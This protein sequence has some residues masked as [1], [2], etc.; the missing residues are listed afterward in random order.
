MT[1]P[2]PTARTRPAR[3]DVAGTLTAGVVLSAAGLAALLLSA[4]PG[5]LTHAQGF[6]DGEGEG[7]LGA[8]KSYVRN[9]VEGAFV[10]VGLVLAVAALAC[11]AV[12]LVRRRAR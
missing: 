12:A 10:T 2:A 7:D 4:L 5:A 8:L 9:L 6:G 11:F 3:P 1:S